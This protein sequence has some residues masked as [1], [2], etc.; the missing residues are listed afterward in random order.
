ML[1][2]QSIDTPALR[3]RIREAEQAARALI[4]R[5]AH[6]EKLAARPHT[7]A[8]DRTRLTLRAREL[9]AAAEPLLREI[10]ELSRPPAL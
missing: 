6:L 5:A 3:V 7:D 10:C 1:V 4:S 2:E 8:A 9:R